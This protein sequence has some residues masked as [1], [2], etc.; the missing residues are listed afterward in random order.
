MAIDVLPVARSPRISSRWPRPIENIEIDDEETGFERFG[1]EVSLANARRLPLDRTIGFGD[2]RS[3]VV[4]RSTKGIDNASKQAGA[5][6][7]ACRFAETLHLEARLDGVRVVQQHHPD[8]I[9]VERSSKSK[10]SIFEVKQFVKVRVGQA[11]NEGDAVGVAL[12][13]ADLAQDRAELRL[14]QTIASAIEPGRPGIIATGRRLVVGLSHRRR[15]SPRCARDRRADCFAGR[16]DGLPAP[17]R[18]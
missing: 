5:D 2:D 12:D 7:S 8:A 17:A 18:R 11:R 1:D 15:A 16:R 10:A 3:A 9:D 14:R 4:E 6:G 13:A